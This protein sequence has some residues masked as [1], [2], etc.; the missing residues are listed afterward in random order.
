METTALLRAFNQRLLIVDDDVVFCEIGQQ[1]FSSQGYE[2]RTAED[3]FEAL[4]LMKSAL[5]DIIVCDLNMPR[6]SGFEFLSVVR[7]R[8]PHIPVVALSGTYGSEWPTGLIADA[9]F[10]KGGE[11][12][13]AQLVQKIKDL[14]DRAPLRAGI[15]KADHAPVWIPFN[16]KPYFVLTCTHCLRSFSVPAQKDCRG[17]RTEQKTKCEFCN[18]EI[19]YIVDNLA[20]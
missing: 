20:A 7:K 10:Q 14:L 6:M 19:S 9:F 2:V 5:P 4:A 1:L 16:G 3:G 11:H 18:T 13:P 8:F 15:V 17:N 12:S